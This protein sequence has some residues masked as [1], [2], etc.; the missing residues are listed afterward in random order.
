[1]ADLDNVNIYY[2]GEAYEVLG[3]SLRN[4]KNE[5]YHVDN[6][7]DIMNAA[8]NSQNIYIIANYTAMFPLRDELI[9]LQNSR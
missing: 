4:V 9:S 7:K 6:V 8:A 3:E 1:M 2:G 5:I